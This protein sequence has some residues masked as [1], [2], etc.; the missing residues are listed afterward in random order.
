MNF[1]RQRIRLGD[2]TGLPFIS[3]A[4][5]DR[6]S[7]ESLLS[8]FHPVEQCNLEYT[9]ER[10]SAIDPH[11]D[12]SWLWGERLVTLN[13]LSDTVLTMSLD[14]GWGG[15]SDGEVRVSVA[16]PRRALILLYGD[17]RHRWKHSIHRQHVQTRRVCSTF[18]ELSSDFLEGGKQEKV[19][20]E[21]LNVASSYKG[22]PL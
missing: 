10:G 14:K 3:S 6:M 16:L 2:F 1:K 11:L 12:D 22:V 21:L 8:G 9:S 17:A 5:V 4:L 20:A 19:G 13:L 15:M 18:R 7:K